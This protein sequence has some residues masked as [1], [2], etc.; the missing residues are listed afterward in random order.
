MNPNNV[1]SDASKSSFFKS[2]QA[3]PSIMDA[4]AVASTTQQSQNPIKMPRFK[5]SIELVNPAGREDVFDT[6]EDLE[7]GEEAEK[8]GKL[9]KPEV[10]EEKSEKSENEEG[11][12]GEI[13]G[14]EKPEKP[15]KLEK[16]ENEEVETEETQVTEEPKGSEKPEKPEN[17]ESNEKNE[18][19]DGETEETEET[20]VPQASN[21]TLVL[22][23]I[24]TNSTT[25]LSNSMESVSSSLSLLSMNH[26]TVSPRAHASNPPKGRSSKRKSSK[27]GRKGRNARRAKLSSSISNSTVST[28]STNSTEMRETVETVDPKE[29]VNLSEVSSL[30]FNFSKFYRDFST[31]PIHIETPVSEWVTG[32]SIF[33]NYVNDVFLPRQMET[34]ARASNPIIY[35]ARNDAK[36]EQQMIGICDVF[37]LS[38]LY[39][40]PFKCCRFPRGNDL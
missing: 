27:H 24:P 5:P 30:G 28:V 11:E 34:V 32:S 1:L 8:L 33:Q 13:G 6:V 7:E 35:V 26:T 9:G 29:P 12:T 16:S 22:T 40:R 39:N 3:I 4:N 15:E 38:L 37:L 23:E 18:N 31:L 19:E 21:E 14:S 10:S 36:L 17:S 20:A 25:L 2:Q